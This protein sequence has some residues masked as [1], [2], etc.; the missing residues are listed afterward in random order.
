MQPD[1]FLDRRRR[2]AAQHIQSQ[3]R[4]DLAE[5]KLHGPPS[6]IQRGDRRVG[7]LLLI[8]QGRDPHNV[9]GSE[10][11]DLD[12][13]AHDAHVQNRRQFLPERFGPRFDLS[14]GFEPT[15]GAARKFA[16]LMHPPDHVDAFA[17]QQRQETFR[18]STNLN[19]RTAALKATSGL[20]HALR[21]KRAVDGGGIQQLTL[22][23]YL[24]QGPVRCQGVLG[25]G[26]RL[27]I[28]DKGI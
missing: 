8:E 12:A 16:R 20:G 3:R 13:E 5:A 2:L 7:R 19:A 10:A 6:P 23:H 27:V 18:A 26:S 17:L 21:I 4:L 1:L 24:P 14:P 11:G 25:D 15:P 9:F 22:K 28:A